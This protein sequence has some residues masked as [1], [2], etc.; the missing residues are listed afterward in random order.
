M[1]QPSGVEVLLNTS[2]EIAALRHNLDIRSNDKFNKNCHKTKTFKFISRPGKDRERDVGKSK[3]TWETGINNRNA[4]GGKEER[5]VSN[6][7]W[8]CA[9]TE[10]WIMNIVVHSTFPGEDRWGYQGEKGREIAA[11]FRF[12]WATQRDL[13]THHLSPIYPHVYPHVDKYR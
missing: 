11:R 10:R 7:L 2:L 6:V 4:F 5:E 13:C 12:E 1:C 9:T 8:W 3:L